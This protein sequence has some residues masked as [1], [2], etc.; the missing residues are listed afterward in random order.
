MRGKSRRYITGEIND[1]APEMRIEVKRA[2]WTPLAEAE[3]QLAYS[4]ERKVLRLATEHLAERGLG[5]I[6]RH[7]EV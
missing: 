4:S 7:S 3:R 6:S 2:L 5:P 1:I